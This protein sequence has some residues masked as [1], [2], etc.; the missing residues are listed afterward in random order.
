M[1]EEREHAVEGSRGGRARGKDRCRWLGVAVRG[2]EAKENNLRSSTMKRGGHSSSGTT[3]GYRLRMEEG[4]MMAM[5]RWS[6]GYH[7]HVG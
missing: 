3:E 5:V 7:A 1:H 4:K 6:S 2:V